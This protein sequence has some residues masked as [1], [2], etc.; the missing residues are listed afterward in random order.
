MKLRRAMCLPY[1]APIGRLTPQYEVE[2]SLALPVG[3]PTSEGEVGKER[4]PRH[5]HPCLVLHL[6][7]PLH[8]RLV[9]ALDGVVRRG[10]DEVSQGGDA[11]GTRRVEPNHAPGAWCLVRNDDLGLEFQR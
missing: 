9:D 8:V 1:A 6:I 10:E 7:P 3:L 5:R 4:R 2:F 11:G